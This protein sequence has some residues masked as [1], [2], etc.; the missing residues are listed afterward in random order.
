M[1]RQYL[2]TSEVAEA[3]GVHPNTVRMYEVWGLLPPIPRTWSGYRK[4]IAMHV[5][6]MRLACLVFDGP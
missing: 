1:A 4:F 6:Q 2:R 5:D 3:V